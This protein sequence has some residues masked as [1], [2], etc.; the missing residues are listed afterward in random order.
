HAAHVLD[1][2]VVLVSEACVSTLSEPDLHPVQSRRDPLLRLL[3]HPPDVLVV[4]VA[5]SDRGQP[6]VHRATEQLKDRS[7]EDLALYVPQGDVDGGDRVARDAPVVSIPPGLVRSE[8][9]RVG[10][11]CRWRW[12]R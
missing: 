7:T 1:V 2:P 10:K 11:E 3:D 9:R 8:E 6:L 5:R 4:G 12:T